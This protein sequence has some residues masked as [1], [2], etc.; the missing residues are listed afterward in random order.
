MKRSGVYIR[1]A[2]TGDKYSAR[3]V[4]AAVTFVVAH[5]L[6][7]SPDARCLDRYL[8]RRHPARVWLIGDQ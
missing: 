5:H 7:A 2:R 1:S 4:A 8:P 3:C 6:A